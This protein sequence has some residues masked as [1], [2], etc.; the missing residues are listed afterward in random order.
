MLPP[1]REVIPHS[2]AAVRWEAA[3]GSPTESTAAITSRCQ[4][5]GVPP[6]ANT[7]GCSRTKRPRFA[8]ASS[9]LRESPHDS[10]WA[11]VKTLCCEEARA[12]R[13]RSRSFTAPRCQAGSVD[14]T[15]SVVRA[16]SGGHMHTMWAVC[17]PEQ[18][19]VTIWRG[20]RV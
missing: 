2:S 12:A 18:A 3:A 4:V 5:R 7:L 1:R 13:R 15:P 19:R 8:R 11:A 9:A 17:P 16:C 14:G 6:M 10:A 20:S